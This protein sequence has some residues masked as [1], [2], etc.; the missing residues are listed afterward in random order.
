MFLD[1]CP[2]LRQGAPGPSG[3][4]K[5]RFAGMSFVQAPVAFEKDASAQPPRPPI[6]R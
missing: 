5:G 2:I 1:A 6:Q 3:V 4:V